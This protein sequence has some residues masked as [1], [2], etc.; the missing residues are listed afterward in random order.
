MSSGGVMFITVWGLAGLVILIA[1]IL[2]FR[3]S[4]RIEKE[5]KRR[6]QMMQEAIEHDDE[7]VHT[8]EFLTEMHRLQQES[9]GTFANG[10]YSGLSATYAESYSLLGGTLILVGGG[11]LIF[12]LLMIFLSFTPH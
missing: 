5:G 8:Y 12:P 11:L 7:I 9:Y 3:A 1:G 6:L 4:V 10:G 2:I